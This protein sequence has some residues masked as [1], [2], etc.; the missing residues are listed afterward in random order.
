MDKSELFKKIGNMNLDE[1]QSYYTAAKSISKVMNFAGVSLILVMI[2]FYSIATLII[3]SMLVYTAAQIGAF[4]DR[5][6][7]FIEERITNLSDK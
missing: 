4:M 7:G 6:L 5:A 3:G 2:F 1:L